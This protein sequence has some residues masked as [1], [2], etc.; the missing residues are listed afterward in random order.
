MLFYGEGVYFNF[1]EIKRNFKNYP[2]FEVFCYICRVMS[3][4]ADIIQEELERL[5]RMLQAKYSE[6]SLFPKGSIRRRKIGKQEFLYRVHRDGAKVHTDYLC[7]MNDS[8]KYA[9][10]IKEGEQKL[11]LKRQ[12][13]E[14]K[15]ETEKMRRGLG[16]FSS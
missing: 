5:E 1:L 7:S 4:V 3:L 12:I 10:F 14:I 8:E 15:R 9:Q 13:K 6:L 2:T 16:K 11:A